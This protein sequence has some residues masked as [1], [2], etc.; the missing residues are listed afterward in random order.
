MT[1]EPPAQ[2]IRPVGPTLGIWFIDYS[3]TSTT[4]EPDNE[5]IYYRFDWGD[6]SNSGWLGP[7]VSG[8]PGTASHH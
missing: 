8:Q 4:T 5:Q 2:P 1:S 7:Y 3:Y 6:G